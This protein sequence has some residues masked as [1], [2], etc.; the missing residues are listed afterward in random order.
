MK[1]STSTPLRSPD[2]NLNIDNSPK[3]P[4]SEMCYSGYIVHIGQM[5]K[6]STG[7]EYFG[8]KF[9]FDEHELLTVRVMQYEKE[10]DMFKSNKGKAISINATTSRNT[11]FFNKKFKSKIEQILY[12]LDFNN[13]LVVTPLNNDLSK[14]AS[15][16]VVQGNIKWMGDARTTSFGH[17]VR[18]AI[19]KDNSGD[20]KLSLWNSLCDLQENK[21][22]IFTDMEIKQYFGTVMSSSRTTAVEEK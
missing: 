18:D 22:Y 11:T 19:L 9:K 4:S 3:S 1:R 5:C 17:R 6:A 16:V 12:K 15:L 13:E 20:I 10:F 21:S 2:A 14:M 8:I 7:N